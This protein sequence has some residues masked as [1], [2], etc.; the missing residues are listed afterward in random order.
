[1]IFE[2][3]TKDE[4]KELQQQ[5]IFFTNQK[6]R[7]MKNVMSVFTLSIV[8]MTGLF[9][10]LKKEKELPAIQPPTPNEVVTQKDDL[11]LKEKTAITCNEHFH[12]EKN[13]ETNSIDFHDPPNISPIKGNHKV[14]SSF[15]MRFH[16]VFKKEKF[17]RGMDFKAA[18]G[19]PVLATSNGIVTKAENQ[20]KG[21]GN[22][23]VIKHDDEYETLYG[24]LHEIKIAVGQKVFQGDVIGTVGSSGLSTV[25]HLHYEVIKAGKA[26][27]PIAYCNP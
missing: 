23:I 18:T 27:D 14:T 8:L 20:K 11:F 22:F 24:H 9:F 4:L 25:P 6:S 15:G 21:Y 7:R 17:H 16:P 2:A 12:I 19:T 13:E 10:F 3:I 26:V 1:M 5:T